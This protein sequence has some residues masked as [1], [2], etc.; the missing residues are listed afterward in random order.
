MEIHI[1]SFLQNNCRVSTA[2]YSPLNV[3]RSMNGVRGKRTSFE[4]NAK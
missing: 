2:P 3:R 1:Y 4:N